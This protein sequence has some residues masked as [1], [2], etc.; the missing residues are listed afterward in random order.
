MSNTSMPFALFRFP[1]NAAHAQA[2]HDAAAAITSEAISHAVTESVRQ[3]RT[4]GARLYRETPQRAQWRALFNAAVA[5]PDVVIA[6]TYL[7]D[8]LSPR[9]MLCQPYEV[10]SDYTKRYVTVWDIE[11]GDYR[12]VNLDAIVKLTLETHSMPEQF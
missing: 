4:D 6:V 3:C 12:R 10:N 8:D 9:T 1:I 7:K 2:R 5:L 11:A